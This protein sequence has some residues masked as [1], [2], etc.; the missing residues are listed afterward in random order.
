MKVR[1]AGKAGWLIRQDSEAAIAI[2]D[3]KADFPDTTTLRTLRPSG[4]LE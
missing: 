2:F 4:I 1:R 3:A